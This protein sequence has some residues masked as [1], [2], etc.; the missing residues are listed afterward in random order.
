[1]ST[2]IRK[3]VDF[4][5]THLRILPLAHDHVDSVHAIEQTVFNQPWSKQAFSEIVDWNQPCWIAEINGEVAGY[6]ITQWIVDEIHILNIAVAESYRRRGIASALF[7]HML[8]EALRQEMKNMFL[9]VRVS[10]QAAMDFYSAYG[11]Q[12]LVIR[13]RYY[14]DGEDAWV[15]AAPVLPEQRK[16][17][18]HGAND[19][20]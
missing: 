2:V 11:F 3:P 19:G 6:L 16:F 15:M 5:E 12:N 1:M 10:N 14:E 13:K 17:E 4:V 9:E 8:A 20:H 7:E 18:E